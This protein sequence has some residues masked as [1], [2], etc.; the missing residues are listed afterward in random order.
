MEIMEQKDSM[1]Q[2]QSQNHGQLLSGVE[3]I[4]QKLDMPHQQQLALLDR[5]LGSPKGIMDCTAAAQVLQEKMDA[6]LLPGLGKMRAVVEQ[7][8]LLTN[9]QEK[10]A[11]RLAIH[12]NNV[13]IQQGCYS[14]TVTE[15]FFA[16]GV[17]ADLGD[18][19]VNIQTCAEACSD[20]PYL[21][22]ANGQICICGSVLGD[23]SLVGDCDLECQGDYLQ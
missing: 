8:E 13:F 23:R 7:R 20:S 19:Q 4:M 14:H 5:D 15:P 9:L 6:E 21:G 18:Q 1:I 2:I 11:Q 3:T 22:L 17:Q 12:L 10:F 16:D